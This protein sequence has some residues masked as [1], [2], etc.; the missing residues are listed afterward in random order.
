MSVLSALVIDGNRL[1]GD[2]GCT[3]TPLLRMTSRRTLTK[4]DKRKSRWR[5]DARGKHARFPRDEIINLAARGFTRNYREQNTTKSKL[6][7]FKQQ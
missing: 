1:P 3:L 5:C 2:P 4:P 6:N 7:K